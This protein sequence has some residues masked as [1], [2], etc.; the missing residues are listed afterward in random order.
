VLV[1]LALGACG[2][3]HAAAPLPRALGSSST[4]GRHCG[5]PADPGST[6]LTVHVGDRARPVRVYVP[7]GY[8][9]DQPRA[10]VLNLHGSGSTGPRHAAATGMDGTA[11]AHGFLV[12]YPEGLRRIGT[13]YGWNIPGTPTWQ[14]HG[15]DEDSFL[16]RLIAL[17]HERY[18]VDLSRVYLVGFSGGGRM[19]SQFACATDQPIAAVAAVGGLRAPT[20]CPV[21]PV[22][23]MGIHGTAD[24][25]NPYDGHGQPYWTYGVPEAAARWA[26]HDACGPAPVVSRPQPG[27]T[28][29]EYHGCRA[30]TAVLLYT[31]A[32]RGH[33]WPAGRNGSFDSNETIWRFFAAHRLGGAARPDRQDR[34]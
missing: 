3:A 11:E 6:V 17:L 16:G 21:A 27:V 34:T 5:E 26:V 25:Q 31:L 28:L 12:A 33:V 4:S 13:G 24:V 1:T 20:P 2:R 10:L 8:R 29:T 30:E 23:V 15:P 7:H 19:A 22:P 14:V 32:G 18:C 9:P